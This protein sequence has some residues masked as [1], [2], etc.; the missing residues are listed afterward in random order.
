MGNSVD[1]MTFLP[2]EAKEPKTKNNYTMPL[3]E[4]R[5]KLRVL[6]SAIVG[7]EGWDTS[8]DKK[9]PVR[10][11]MGEEPPFGP[12]GKSPKYFWAFVVWN[13]EQERVQ[14]MAVTQKT[15]R[16][17]LQALVDDEAWGDP[18]EYDIALTRKGTKLD[19]TEYTLMPNPK[20]ELEGEIGKA[21]KDTP[22]DLEAWMKGEDPFA[23]EDK[24]IDP[25][26]IPFD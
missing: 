20:T 11:A 17:Q 1:N 7:Y 10:Y 23:K 21:Y 14:I 13:Y 9:V 8:G 22:V 16:T 6:S 3:D 2:S 25:A 18:K 26:D 15:I 4:G 12:D 5:H 19:D 24:G